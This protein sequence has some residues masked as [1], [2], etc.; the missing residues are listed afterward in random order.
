MK[1]DIVKARFE[2]LNAAR[3]GEGMDDNPYDENNDLHFEWLA[4]WT[5]YKLD[6][7]K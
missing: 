5:S 1:A 4:A 6:K 3:K 7:L 2:G